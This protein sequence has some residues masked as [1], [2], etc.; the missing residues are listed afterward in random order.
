[1]RDGLRQS[2]DDLPAPIV[3]T[4]NAERR[5]RPTTAFQN[6]TEDRKPLIKPAVNVNRKEQ[7]T[8]R[9]AR[10]EGYAVLVAEMRF[11]QPACEIPR[12]AVPPRAVAEMK[13]LPSP[14]A[15]QKSI[16]ARYE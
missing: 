6:V 11:E 8:S 5:P 16:E 13:R 9:G 15:I 1:M 4:G 3:A 10:P 12:S 14:R 2:D 7:G